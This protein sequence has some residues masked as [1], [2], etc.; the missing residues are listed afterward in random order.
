[1]KVLTVVASEGERVAIYHCVPFAYTFRFAS[2]NNFTHMQHLLRLEILRVPIG[3]RLTQTAPIRSIVRY[4]LS[5]RS[6]WALRNARSV[7]G[8]TAWL[9]HLQN[10]RS[11]QEFE[12]LISA[13]RSPHPKIHLHSSTHRQRTPHVRFICN[14]YSRQPSVRF[15]C[16]SPAWTSKQNFLCRSDAYSV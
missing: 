16:L 1:M 10:Q 3:W 7:F 4:V 12:L 14:P 8:S 13:S 2:C 11:F 15:A 9:Q 6:F 5:P